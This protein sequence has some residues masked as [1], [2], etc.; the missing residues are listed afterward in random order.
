MNKLIRLLI[1]RYK[2]YVLTLFCTTA[3]VICLTLFVP[4]VQTAAKSA[5]SVHS[6]VDSIGINV[7]LSYLD[8]VYA[9][10]EDLVKP[11]LKELG[12]RHIRDNGSYAQAQLNK[13]SNLATR[14]IK[15]TVI[16]DPT[17]IGKASNAVNIVKAV[18]D[19][20]EAVEGPNEWDMHPNLNYEGQNFPDGVRKFQA[21]LYSVIKGNSTT[22][23]LDVLSPSLAFPGNAFKLGKVACDIGNIHSYPRGGKVPSNALEK[24]LPAARVICGSKPIISTET[25]YQNAVNERGV[26]EQASAKYLPR[27]LLEHFNGGIKRTYIYELI[28]LKPNPEPDKGEWHF[29]L[30]R[31][32]GSSKPSFIALKNLLSLLGNSNGLTSRSFTPKSLN[33]TL[34]GNTSTIHHTLLQKIDGRFYLILWQDVLSF[35]TKIKTDIVVPESQVILTLNTLI[36]KA[37]TYRPLNSISPLA[38]YTN[39]QQL[40]LMVPDHPLVIELVPA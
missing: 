15:S 28:D 6:F 8:T 10:Y 20:I 1:G 30:L 24:W 26:S 11:K 38:Q 33:Y 4:L 34:S 2:F 29:G 5:R 39:P 13:L 9:R 23:R 31:N 21:D 40:Q 18:A 16:L 35:D 25:G 22:A 17:D 27:L 14:G 37:I 32:D 3:L 12:I 36:K 19:A 7:H